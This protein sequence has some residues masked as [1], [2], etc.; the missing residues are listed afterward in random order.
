MSDLLKRDKDYP[1]RIE[2]VASRFKY[3]QIKAW[4][5]DNDEMLRFY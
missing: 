5:K 2:D 3:G 4:H 1:A